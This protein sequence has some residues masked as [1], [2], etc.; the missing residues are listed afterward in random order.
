METHKPWQ[1][2][3]LE[4]L[5]IGHTQGASEANS[6]GFGFNTAYPNPS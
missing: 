4:D 6:D 5:D 1:S 2:P 3:E